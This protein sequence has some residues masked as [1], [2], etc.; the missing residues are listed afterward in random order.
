MKKLPLC[1]AV[2]IVTLFMACF[3]FVPI[4]QVL[5][6]GFLDEDG[7]LTF[8]YLAEV[9]RN[10]LYIEGLITSFRVAL[11][12]TLLTMLLALPMAWLA[13]RFDFPG[14]KLLSAAILLPMILPPFVGAV[15]MQRILGRYGAFN[16]A[17]ARLG[18]IELANA[19][20]W[21]LTS[22]FWGVVIVEALHLYPILY[23]NAAAAFANVDPLYGEAAANLGCVGFRRFRKITLPLIMPGLFAGGTLVFI[24]S[25]TELGTPLMFSYDRVT[26]VQIFN[27]I[28]EIGTNPFPYALVVV[29][30][31]ASACLYAV[32]KLSLGRT[33]HASSGKAT[34][35]SRQVRLHGLRGW[36]ATL[37]PATV[38]FL[39][40]LPHLGVIGISIAKSWY[41]TVL[42]ESYT[43]S[44]FHVSLGHAWTVPSI[45][46][47]VRYSGFAVIVAVLIGVVVAYLV[48]RSDIRGAWLLDAVAMLPL[49][50]P[51][52]VLAFGY[53]A[54]T[55]KGRFFHFLDPIENPTILL[56]IAY[57]VRRLPYVVRAVVAGLQQTSKTLEEA[58]ANLGAPPLTVF[59]RITVPLI[60]AN[61]LAGALLAFSFAMLEVSDSL[62]LAQ[63]TLYFP[64]TKAIYEL[65]MLLGQG[66]AMAAS[67]GVWTM[68]FLGASIAIVGTL[69]GKRMGALFRV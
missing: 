8:A 56:V 41:R 59:R 38:C 42:P 2:A 53:L 60:A 55:Q 34:V 14:K 11:C 13:D 9:F 3:F 63:K 39:A 20:D 17:L 44:H 66:Q 36:T 21:L 61:L 67:L 6:G 68:V 29:M 47:S 32:A 65:S 57:A 19:P 51:G 52:L 4:L 27:G 5:R 28:N 46:N 50:V 31:T 33:A 18:I 40:V 58:G 25:F 22:G 12:T 64:I 16:A 15:G 1:G 69:L 10:P 7:H 62:I 23:L 37:V 54:M 24:W 30:M 45:M 49:A 48:V 26:P 43:L 35:A